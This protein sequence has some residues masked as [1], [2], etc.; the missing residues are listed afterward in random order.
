MSS[1]FERREF[2]RLWRD[3]GFDPKKRNECLAAAGYAPSTIAHRG[4]KIARSVQ[5]IVVRKMEKKGLTLDKVVE[6]HKAALD[7]NDPK[8]G[9]PD[10]KTRLKAADMYYN[11]IDAY[12][13][14]KVDVNTHGSMSVEISVETLRAAEAATGENIIDVIP[15]DAIEEGQEDDAPLLPEHDADSDSP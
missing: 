1:P 6:T 12:P 9:T 15:E 10:H 4:K 2:Y 8:F 7:A 3:S 13:S 5:E 11:M 14:Q